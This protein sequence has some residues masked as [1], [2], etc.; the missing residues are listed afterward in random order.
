MNAYEKDKMQY[1]TSDEKRR[2][3]DE[4]IRVL[5]K[6][7]KHGILNHPDWFFRV[8]VLDM[9]TV[10]LKRLIQWFKKCSYDDYD[11]IYKIVR[12][13]K[14]L[15]ADADSVISTDKF[16]VNRTNLF[17]ISDENIKKFT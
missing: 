6:Y 10:E 9:L 7:D 16:D 1:L 11:A 17:F 4:K 13:I 3:F 12:K 2:Y 14:L 5:R 8:V 15:E